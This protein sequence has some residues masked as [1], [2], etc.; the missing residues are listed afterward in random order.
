MLTFLEFVCF[1]L[2]GPPTYSKGNG[3]SYW[4]C[5]KCS[6]PRFHTMPHVERYRDR[7]RCFACPFRGDAFD[8]LGHFYPRE[9]Y[10]DRQRRIAD[11]ERRYQAAAQKGTT[12]V[13]PTTSPHSSFRG[14]S[15]SKGR[16]YDPGTP[17]KVEEAYAAMSEEEMQT[18]AAA[19]AIAKR[20]GVP[21]DDLAW[22][23][24][25]SELWVREKEAK[26]LAECEDPDCDWAVCRLNRGW[27]EEEI[28]A[29][30]QAHVQEQREQEEARRKRVEMF[31][32]RARNH[33]RNGEGKRHADH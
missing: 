3:E 9:D 15:G 10:G 33:C 8:L 16:D 28:Q 17:R 20:L 7:V 22:Y 21:V 25:H 19:C 30:I 4:P 24:Y 32:Q 2:I 11:L 13:T 1:E 26:H 23:C 18:L 6:H 14:V 29:D 27:T 31:A 12:P 5:P